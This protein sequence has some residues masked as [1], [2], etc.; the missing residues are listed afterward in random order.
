M[1]RSDALTA[2]SARRAPADTSPPWWLTA[3]VAAA[4]GLASW[5]ILEVHRHGERI[6]SLESYADT[7]SKTLER[8]ELKVDRLLERR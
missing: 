4:T 2:Q 3:G 7:T 1:S 8:V 5:A 6:S